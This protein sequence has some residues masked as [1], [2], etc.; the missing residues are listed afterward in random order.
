MKALGPGSIA[1]DFTGAT[2]L[3]DNLVRT[4]MRVLQTI[5]QR[6]PAAPRAGPAGHAPGEGG[7][8][9]DHRTARRLGVLAVKNIQFARTARANPC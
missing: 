4:G 3:A 6:R 2:D 7:H 9:R 5:G 1:D 8:A